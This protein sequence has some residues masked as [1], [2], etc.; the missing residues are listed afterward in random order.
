MSNE[1]MG[2]VSNTGEGGGDDGT[3]RTALLRRILQP[4]CM[5]RGGNRE[6]RNES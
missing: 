4:M 2:G 6:K 5:V 1:G 3:P